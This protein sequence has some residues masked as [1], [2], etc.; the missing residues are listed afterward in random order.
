MGCRRIKRKYLYRTLIKISY[1]NFAHGDE[2][3][4]VVY[5][6]N[7]ARLRELK[8]KY[9]PENVF[10]H[11]FDI[12]QDPDI[13]SGSNSSSNSSSSTIPSTGSNGT[14][15]FTGAASTIRADGLIIAISFVAALFQ[16]FQ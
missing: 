11:W 5:F 8:K 10:N 15:P 9:D 4:E 2:P 6:N 3:N 14:T 13:S 16:S 1:I 7:T 12:V